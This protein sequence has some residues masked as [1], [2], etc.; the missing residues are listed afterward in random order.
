MSARKSG[1]DELI[2]VTPAAVREALAVGGL[3]AT[4]AKRP[5]SASIRRRAMARVPE[6][7][8]GPAIKPASAL[9][10]A[11]DLVARYELERSNA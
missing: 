11:I 3:H 6:T 5:A 10:A 9:G 8:D 4:S 2:G 1:D 7:I